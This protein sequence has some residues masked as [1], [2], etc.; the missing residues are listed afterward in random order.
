MG[1]GFER[2]RGLYWAGTYVTAKMFFLLGIFWRESKAFT[3]GEQSER[4]VE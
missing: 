4:L 3:F 1:S 2:Q